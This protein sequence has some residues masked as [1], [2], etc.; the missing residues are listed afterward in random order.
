VLEP[1]WRASD[2]ASDTAAL[3]RNLVR[4]PTSILHGTKDDNVPVSEARRMEEMLRAAGGKPEVHYQEGAG[5][6]WD[7][8]A[9]PGVDCVDWPPFFEMFRRNRIPETPPPPAVD[10]RPPT[11]IGPFKRLFANRFVLVYGT[12]GNDAEDRAA[13]ERARFDA[14]A[15]WFRGN[16]LA[17]LVSDRDLL[18]AP[19]ACANRNVV[20]YG[21]RDTNAA[22]RDVL[23]DACP[24]S[25][26]RGRASAGSR[27]WEGDDLAALFCYPRRGEPGSLA[28]AVAATGAPGFRATYLTSIFSSGVGYPDFVV[29]GTDVAARGDGGVRLAGFY[30]REGKVVDVSPPPSSGR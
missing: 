10:P 22:W 9:S 17:L 27:S 24:V 6:W 11:T 16:G 21:N 4:I 28:G 25:L 18:A 23:P 2:P 19:A 20:L 14:E 26:A 29:F 15:W 13:L 1:L 12:A 5:H 3:V 30:D 8:D 7:G